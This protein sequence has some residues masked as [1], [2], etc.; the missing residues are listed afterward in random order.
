MTNNSITILNVGHGNSTIIN[1][2]D[3]YSIVDA[4]PKST[5]LGFLEAHSIENIDCLFLSHSDLDHIEGTIT[6]LADENVKIKKILLNSDSLKESVLWKDLLYVIEDHYRNK[7]IKPELGLIEGDSFPL[8]D[9]RL[10]IFT[11]S[12]FLAASGA[13]S[14]TK[15]GGKI[16]SNS[17][18]LCIILEHSG[19]NII[20]LP[21]DLDE[22]GYSQIPDDLKK[23][24]VCDYLIFPHH[25]GKCKGDYLKYYS[26]LLNDINPSTI[27]FSN[28]RGRFGNP[29]SEV[30]S[31]IKE[32]DQETEILCTQ[33][34]E[35]CS[36][37]IP[38]QNHNIFDHVDSKRCAGDISILF[39][40]EN[41]VVQPDLAI[42]KTFKESL[43]TPQCQQE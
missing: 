6:L 42:Y 11:P 39:G 5:V 16:D 1:C 41:M 19:K 9:A 8:D 13:G 15:S 31:L 33:L 25:G 10:K 22:L 26:D 40:S 28:G 29:R 43:S 12:F 7:K 3:T 17:V 30:L 23:N 20:C 34:S 27:I 24:M 4:G 14:K 35:Q 21:G 37:D 32:R 2:N 18:S 38:I 36:A